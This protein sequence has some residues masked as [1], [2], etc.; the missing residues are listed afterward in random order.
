MADFTSEQFIQQFAKEVAEQ[1]KL[2]QNQYVDALA[3]RIV[4]SLSGIINVKVPANTPI[5]QEQKASAQKPEETQ[6]RENYCRF[7]RLRTET[8]IY[9]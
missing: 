6:R 5:T 8:K 4:K 9:S 7:K 2:T 3:E 1:F